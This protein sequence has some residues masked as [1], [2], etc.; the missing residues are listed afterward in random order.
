MDP[1]A[2]GIPSLDFKPRALCRKWTPSLSRR[3]GSGR[4]GLSNFGQIDAYL[5]RASRAPSF[6]DKR[7]QLFKL[8]GGVFGQVVS[9]PFSAWQASVKAVQEDVISSVSTCVNFSGCSN[10]LFFFAKS[11]LHPAAAEMSSSACFELHAC[12]EPICP[13]RRRLPHKG[14]SGRVPYGHKTV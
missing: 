1:L 10:V 4:A 11:L 14:T 8:S 12:C 6:S 2:Q 13:D 9:D 3:H 7:F 5:R